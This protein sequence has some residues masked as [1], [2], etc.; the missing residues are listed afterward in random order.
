M[1]TTKALAKLF[2]KIV[3]SETK[4]NS[5]TKIVNDLADNWKLPPVPKYVGTY[6]LTV[7]ILDDK[8]VYLW[9]PET[10][11]IDPDNPPR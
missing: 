9:T 11:E 6:K 10:I 4:K 5:T 1:T 2:K 3:G 8:K 7:A